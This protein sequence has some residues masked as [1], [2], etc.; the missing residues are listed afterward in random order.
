MSM[1]RQPSA[2]KHFGGKMF[3]KLM[4]NNATTAPTNLLSLNDSVYV[5]F[6]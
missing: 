3:N 4:F 2:Q 5:I 1:S 6:P